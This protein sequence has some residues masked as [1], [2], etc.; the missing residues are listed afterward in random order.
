MSVIITEVKTKKELRLFVKF[1]MNLY[2]DSPY[3]VPNLYFDEMNALDPAKNP[4]CKYSKFVRFLAWKDGKVVGRVAGIINEIANRDW[5]H[6]EVRFGWF[7]FVD[8][9]EVSKALLE[10]VIEWGKSYGMTQI[11]GP[12][13]FTDFDNEGMVVEGF[14]QISS[15]MLKFNY[16]YYREH[17][18]ALGY[19]K[20]IDWQEYRIFV[21]EKV[22][23]KVSRIAEIVADRYKLHVRNITKRDINKE[24]Y[25]QK[26]F[27]LINRTYCELYDFTV[28]PPEVIDSYVDT[29]LGFIDL[30]YVVVIENEEGKLVALAITMPSLAHA[31]Q[32]GGG[33]LFPFGWWHI[34][35][36]MYLKHEEALELMLI[37]VDPDYRNKGVNAMLFNELIPRIIEGGFKYGE[38]N[39]E[40]E[41]N[42]KV[43][44]QWDL[45]E[46][47]L[48][49]VRRIFGKSI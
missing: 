42:N 9:R 43:Q 1:P 46:K 12:L 31:V 16:P 23:E 10:K 2:K 36:S 34:V 38:S 3:Y 47:Q 11:S 20:V 28:L 14:D 8:D 25:G 21:P 44:N 5:D 39:A 48:Q 6:K 40:L 49:R 24:K 4:M 33:Y 27:D 37:A 13:G 35:K 41:T 45:Y 19:E 30:R 17:M 22:P 32:K 26:L 29:Y 15:F 18:E 7:D